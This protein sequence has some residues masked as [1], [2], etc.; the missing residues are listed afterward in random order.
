MISCGGRKDTEEKSLRSEL[1]TPVSAAKEFF[2]TPYYGDTTKL[3]SFQNIRAGINSACMRCHMAPAASGGF[4]YIDSYRGG[5]TTVNG[6]TRFY[7]GFYEAAEQIREA[8]FHANPQKRMPPSDIRDKNPEAFLEIGRQIDAWVAAGKVEGSFKQDGQVPKPPAGKPRP[9]RPHHTSELGDCIPQAKLVGY[10]Y[11]TDRKFEKAKTLPKNLTETD[12]FDLDPYALAQRGTVAYNV[13]YPLWADNANKGRWIHVPMKLEN[14]RLRRQAVTY[15]PETKQFKIPENTRFYKSFYKAVKRA[16]GEIKMRRMETRVIVA[17]TPWQDSLFGTYQWDDSEQVATLLETPY[18]DGTPWKDVVTDIIVD[19]A[20]NTLRPYGIPGRQRCVDCHMG[21]PNQNF[22]LGFI[23]LQINKRPLG[24]AG[25][26]ELPAPHDLDQVSRFIS[27]GFIKGIEKESDLPIL[28]T[29]GSAP[30]RNVHELRAQGY[31]VGNCFH[32]HNPLGLAFTP[33]NGIRFGMAP[34]DIFSF[35]TQQQSVQPPYR[36]L[37][38]YKGELESSHIWRKIVDPPAQ[39]GMFSQMPMHT[40]GAPDCY[41]MTVVGK[42]IRSFESETEANGWEPECKKENPFFWIDM[43]FTWVRSDKFVPRRDD[44]DHETAGMPKKYRDL[45]LSGDLE[46]AIKK[47]YAVGYWNKK[48]EC[49]F[50]DVNLPTEDRRPWMLKNGQPKRPFGEIYYTTPGSYFYRNT[51]MK[52]HGAKA[53]GDSNLAKGILNWSGGSVRVP[54]FMDGL[55]G[56]K[57]ENLKTFDSDGK[58]YAGN[59]LIWMA[60]GGTKVR[61]PPELS[62]YLGKHG[63]QMLN[64][65]REKCINQISPEKPSS[66][67]F[68]EHEIFRRVCFIYNL[69]PGHPDLAF[70]PETNQALH[71]E[72]VEEW[73]DK[74]AWNAGW[75][76]FDFLKNASDGHWLPSNDQCETVYGSQGGHQ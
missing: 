5:E 51:C 12:M 61:F 53:D 28:E 64:G 30:P 33:E 6:E 65:I 25:R 69:S 36:K 35:N 16:N 67:N 54:N 56:K 45:S 32:C 52:C 44:W 66:P 62:G 7:P 4:S 17:R 74:A 24:G 76:I 26:M 11:A 20:K 38:H 68:I 27:Y 13:E 29:S 75:A 70:D 47:Q 55:F 58:N 22:I 73:A 19:E 71:P 57:N 9:Q 18:R 1:C 63:G 41:V 8:I 42:W 72:K 46:E 34:G 40:P 3:L 15:N 21:S 50:P 14:G 59:Y 49:K 37:V 10:D 39:Q 23:P 43:D 31:M 60:M 48:P 2:E